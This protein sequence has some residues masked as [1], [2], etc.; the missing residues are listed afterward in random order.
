VIARWA[1]RTLLA[2]L[3]A[4]LVVNLRFVITHWSE[5]RT[6][7][8]RA[9]SEAPVFSLPL[10]DGSRFDLTA[11][12]GQPVA[13]AF[14]ATWCDPC[15]TELPQ[16]DQVAKRLGPTAKIIAV[17]IE[18]PEARPE[19]EKFVREHNLGLPV[20]LGGGEVADKFHVETIPN[21]IVLDAQGRVH[22]VLDGLH[23]PSEVEAALKSAAAQP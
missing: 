20:A 14:W 6:V 16:L 18:P 22:R 4:I 8:T 23:A 12:R 7:T 13:I 17:N 1:G 11:A 2:L 5:V 3:L 15:R 10:L 21:L 9:G 19:V